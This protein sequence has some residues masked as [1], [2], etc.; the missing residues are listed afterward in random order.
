MLLL[1]VCSAMMASVSSVDL[2]GKDGKRV[3]CKSCS[4]KMLIRHIY[5]RNLLSHSLLCRVLCKEDSSKSDTGNILA[6]GKT[7]ELAH[8]TSD[9]VMDNTTERVSAIR[10]R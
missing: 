4:L 1:C 6:F 7:S 10:T 9:I 5:K 2:F 8:L 3:P